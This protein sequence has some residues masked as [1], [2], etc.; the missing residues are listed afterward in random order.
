MH[1]WYEKGILSSDFVSHTTDYMNDD[2]IEDIISK[3]TGV[4]S[5]GDGLIDM[6]R[7]VSGSNLVA[8]TDPVLEEGQ[9]IHLGN[10]P[11]LPSTVRGVVITTACEEPEMAAEFLNWWYTDDGFLA[12]SYGQE[13]SATPMVDGKPQFTDTVLNNPD[14]AAGDAISFYT[15]RNNTPSWSSNS[16]LLVSFNEDEAAPLTYGLQA[17]T[18]GMPTLCGAA[19]HR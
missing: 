5:R 13:A 11:A 3:T 16:K 1:D 14:L 8:L 4:F 2:L 10:Q 19:D 18:T 15:G 9:T 17:V 12:S 7:N 6:L